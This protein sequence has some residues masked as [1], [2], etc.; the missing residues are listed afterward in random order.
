MVHMRE[1][2]AAAAEI[3]FLIKPSLAP[4]ILDWAR[5]HLEADSHGTGPFGDEYD[6]CSLYFDT[7]DHDV[8]RRR[9]SFGRAKYRVRRYGASDVVFLERKLRKPGLLIKRRTI[10]PLAALDQLQAEDVP[11]GWGGEWF[12]RRLQVR[13]L[14]PVCEVAY[15]RTAR[16]IETDDGPARMTL[17]RDLRVAAVSEPRFGSDEAVS[18]LEDQLI[19][20]LKYRIRLPAIFRRLVEEFALETAT[21]SKYRLSMTTLGFA[22]ERND[23][24]IVTALNACEINREQERVSAA[25]A[26]APQALRRVRRS[27]G[28]GGNEPRARSG[29]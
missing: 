6:I 29:A 12:H 16:T 7:S 13:R 27:L 23:R 2:R 4:R 22:P 15:H 11:A 28:G 3:K 5:T 18:F 24:A 20:E 25:P 8:F 10:A 19:L 21:A 17:D 26:F 14:Q 1:T 9:S